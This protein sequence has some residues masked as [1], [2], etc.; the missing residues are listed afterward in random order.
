[1]LAGACLVTEWRGHPLL[2]HLLVRPSRRGTGLGTALLSRSANRLRAGGAVDWTLAVTR[3]NPAE[4]LYARC[5]FV[6]DPTLR[7]G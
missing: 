5:G 2:A 4:R 3:G 1:M 6:E 7:S